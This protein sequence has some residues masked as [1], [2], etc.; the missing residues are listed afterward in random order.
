MSKYL[1]LPPM[2]SRKCKYAIKALVH[3]G[4]NFGK[5]NMFT[6][7]IAAG[8]NIPK[9]FLE[10]ILLELKHAGY[11]GSQKGYGGGYYLK[12]DPNDISVADIYRLFDG[13]IAL[14][15]CVAVQY[16]EKCEDCTDEATC[17]YRREFDIIKEKTR[18]VMK[19]ITIASFLKKDPPKQ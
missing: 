17:V 18:E 6:A 8:E 2:M 19:Q 4:A 7:D 12:K 5:G 11:L 15:P 3:L 16:Y 1:S 9:K 13:A 14:V 10:Q